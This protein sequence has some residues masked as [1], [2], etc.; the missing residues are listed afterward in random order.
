[1]AE[2]SDLTDRMFYIESKIGMSDELFG[3]LSLLK[4]RWEQYKKLRE[5]IYIPYLRVVFD[6]A[7]KRATSEVQT[8]ENFQNG[9]IGLMSAISNYNHKRGVFSS[10]ARQW[11]MQGILLRLK[12]EANPIKLP[13]AVWQTASQ[14]NEIAQKHASQSVDGSVDLAE[15]AK[16]AG[17]N[18]KRASKIFERIRSTQ[19][20]SIDYENDDPEHQSLHDTIEDD[21]RAHEAPAVDQYIS[22]LKPREQFCVMLHFGLFDKLP[23]SLPT[24]LMAINR[25]RSR[26]I[27]AAE[28]ISSA[29]DSTGV[30]SVNDL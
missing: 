28:R 17:L 4:A 22:H 30:N 24:D 5:K 29:A 3:V 16:E 10:Y 26:Q 8:L 2:I 23:G 11:A 1:M 6:E 19:M 9:A 25:E 7:R 21:S 27:R 15:V 18:E 12:E 14:L 13:A 20:L